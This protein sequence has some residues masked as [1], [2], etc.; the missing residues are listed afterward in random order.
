MAC[1]LETPQHDELRAVQ[2]TLTR[3]SSNRDA[4]EVKKELEVHDRVKNVV[5]MLWYI[6]IYI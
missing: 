1:I 2:A 4:E 6:Y 5:V 3:Q